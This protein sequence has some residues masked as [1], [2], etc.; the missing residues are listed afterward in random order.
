[1]AASGMMP[2]FFDA[3]A[4]PQRQRAINAL[5]TPGGSTEAPELVQDRVASILDDLEQQYLGSAGKRYEDM[6]QLILRTG[7]TMA[8]VDE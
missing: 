2:Q 5:V 3:M 4:A 6:I 8:F 1:M 7:G